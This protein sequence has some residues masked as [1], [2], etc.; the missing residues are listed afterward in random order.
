MRHQ[1]VLSNFRQKLK[2]L[3][4]EKDYEKSRNEWREF[5]IKV[6]LS[7]LVNYGV[8][9]TIYKEYA[10]EAISIWENNGSPRNLKPTTWWQFWR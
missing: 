7:Y 6:N 4:E 5:C 3:K 10:L 1:E 9:S 2:N 8:T